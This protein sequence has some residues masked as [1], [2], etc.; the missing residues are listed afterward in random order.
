MRR[1]SLPL[2]PLRSAVPPTA[3]DVRKKLGGP[4]QSEAGA[5]LVVRFVAD[6]SAGPGVV[7]FRTGDALDVYLGDGL[8]RRTSADAV[9]TLEPPVPEALSAVAADVRVFAALRQGERVHYQDASGRVLGGVLVE[10]CRYGALVKSDE[11][12]VVGV[13][14]RKLTPAAQTPPA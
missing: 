7:L 8:V 4:G 9:T 12:R 11:Q 14:F 13:G 10:K 1:H 5:G 6:A 3:D 2:H